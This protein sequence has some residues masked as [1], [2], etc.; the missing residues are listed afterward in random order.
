[1]SLSAVLKPPQHIETRSDR[2][3]LREWP[4]HA[5]ANSFVGKNYNRCPA[6]E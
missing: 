2:A 4:N 6:R 1:M 3:R 5:D